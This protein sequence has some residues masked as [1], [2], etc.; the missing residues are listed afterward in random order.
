MVTTD[1]SVP[2]DFPRP[3]IRSALAGF[4]AKLPLVS[5]EGR[6]YAQGGTPPELRNR[7]DICEDLAQ[8][9]VV[10]ATE[11]KA[12]KRAHMSEAEILD[13]YCLRTFKMGWGSDDEMRWV[14]RRTATILGW[15]VPASAATVPVSD[16]LAASNDEQFV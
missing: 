4:Q 2:D 8:Q 15:P 9:F 5:Y 14:I 3:P 13:Q 6:F 10:K 16:E 7:W 12:G 11:S 1:V